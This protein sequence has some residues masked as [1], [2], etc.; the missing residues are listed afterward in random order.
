MGHTFARIYREH[1]AT[2]ISAGWPTVDWS[3][4]KEWN[5]CVQANLHFKK[6]KSASQGMKSQQSPKI[7]A[8][9]ERAIT[10]TT[11]VI[12]GLFES[13][14]PWFCSSQM[15]PVFIKGYLKEP[16]FSK[17][18][19]IQQAERIWVNAE[20]GGFF[21]L[22]CFLDFIFRVSRVT[23]GSTCSAHI[24]GQCPGWHIFAHATSLMLGVKVVYSHCAK[25]QVEEATGSL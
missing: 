7:L 8:S 25:N 3:W 5:E 12:T 19:F 23:M 6:K 15:R 21:L 20:N 9:K 18:C 1:S 24:G 4:H 16:V 17:T 14:K 13:L 10:S 11:R 2:V 22:K